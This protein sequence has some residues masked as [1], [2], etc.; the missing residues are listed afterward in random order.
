MLDREKKILA[1]IRQARVL[2]KFLTATGPS[3]NFTFE[4]N[5]PLLGLYLRTIHICISSKAR[6]AKGVAGYIA[7]KYRALPTPG[8]GL[9]DAMR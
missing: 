4:K 6:V 5:E 2:R 1:R 3:V 7:S 9:P 8:A